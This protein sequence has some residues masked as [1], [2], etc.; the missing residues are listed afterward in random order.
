MADSGLPAAAYIADHQEDLILLVERLVGFRTPNPPG[1]NTGAAQQLVADL[2][3]ALGATV[4]RFE[5]FPGDPDVVGVV[6]GDAGDAYQSLLLNGH[7]DVADAE[8]ES[9][10]TIPPYAAAVRGG[11][12]YGRGT[13]DMKGALAAFLFALQALKATGTRLGGDVIFESVIGE[14]MGEIGTVACNE[15]GYRA[16]FAICGDISDLELQGQGGV[17][18]GWI[19]I[20]SPE[21][22]HDAMRRRMIHAGGGTFGASAIEK[23]TKVI[24]GLQELER[25]WAV[26]KTFPGMPPGSTTINPSVIEGGRHPAFIADRCSLWCTYHFLP[27][28]TYVGVQR[29]VE[30]HIGRVAAADPWLRVHPPTFRWGGRS[31]LVDR[32]EIFPGFAPDREFAGLR[33]LEAIHAGILGR[34]A[35]SGMSP[36]VTDAGWLAMA[37]MP[38][39]LYGPGQIEQAHAVDESVAIDELVAYAMVIA[40]TIATWCNTPRESRLASHA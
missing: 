2:L 33:T 16:D 11:R 24:A 38:T 7:I 35:V 31:M 19:D 18:T 32:G 6:R 36:S 29:E 8:P 1:R 12:I 17:I 13:A 39:V 21:V 30:E 22:F 20:Q 25:H 28:D 40:R 34:P 9:A 4:D 14:E 10:W 5:V 26:T 23:M 3:A 15:R 37:G 27:N